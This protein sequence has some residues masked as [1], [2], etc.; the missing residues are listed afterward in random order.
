M[1]KTF[2]LFNGINICEKYNKETGKIKETIKRKLFIV[3]NC[4]SSHILKEERET[5]CCLS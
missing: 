4:E 5:S 1:P 3:F 2:F